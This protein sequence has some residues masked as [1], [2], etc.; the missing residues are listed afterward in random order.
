MLLFT[1]NIVMTV[2]QRPPAVVHGRAATFQM[3]AYGKR[4]DQGAHI[5]L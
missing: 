3:T 1:I 4:G 5:M 2:R